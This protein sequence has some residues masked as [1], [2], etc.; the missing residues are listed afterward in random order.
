MFSISTRQIKCFFYHYNFFSYFLTVF[1]R[2][3]ASSSCECERSTAPSL[4][5][6]LHL[7]NNKDL[8]AKVSAS[9]GRAA[10][11]AADKRPDEEKVRELYLWA[12]A[13]EPQADELSAAKGY[14]EKIVTRGG[15]PVAGSPDEA[16]RRKQ[17]YEDLVW[18]LINTKE[19][20]FNH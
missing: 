19:F 1:G 8:Q 10:T 15:T 5:Q 4:A 7:L 16:H 18:A 13:R 12:Y 9:G 17:A 20:S 2:P 14:V 6:S 11:L 3:D